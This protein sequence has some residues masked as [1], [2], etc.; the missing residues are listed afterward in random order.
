MDVTT[1][2]LYMRLSR[3]DETVIKNDFNVFV[4]NIQRARLPL[5]EMRDDIN[6]SHPGRE[7]RCSTLKAT[8]Q[9]SR[10]SYVD[11]GYGDMCVKLELLAS[12]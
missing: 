5:N 7:T 10:M 8:L 6:S 2:A 12:Q 1:V 3:E 9:V 11:R 4:W